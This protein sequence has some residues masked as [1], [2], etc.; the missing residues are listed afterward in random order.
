MRMAKCWASTARRTFPMGAGYQEKT[1][2]SPGDTG[3]EVW[4]TTIR[5]HRCGHLLGPVVSG[6]RASHG[7][8]GCGAAAVSHRHRQRAAASLAGAFARSLATH[9]AGACGSQSGAADRIQPNRHRAFAAVPEDLYIRFYGSSFITDA[10][11]A[12]LSEAGEEDEAVI[13][14]E[15]DLAQAAE[16]RDNWFVFRD[17]RPELY[18]HSPRWMGG[19]PRPTD[20]REDPV[21]LP[22][23]HLS[24]P[25]GGGRGAA[26]CGARGAASATRIRFSRHSRLPHR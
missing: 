6:M 23:E 2:F 16:L 25:D 26:A 10:Q 20:A 8:G 24:I 18:A 15:L 21:R 13:V 19:S 7:A 5:A 12:K 4:N 17:R 3:F 11:G 14:A 9:A 22:G 1:Y